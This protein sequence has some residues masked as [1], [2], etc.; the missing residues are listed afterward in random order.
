MFS[1]TR[2]DL[3]RELVEGQAP[4]SALLSPFRSPFLWL[5]YW[6]HWEMELSIPEV[7]VKLYY[8]RRN[9]LRGGR[10]KIFEIEVDP[11]DRL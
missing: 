6:L 11:R 7:R 2:N 5:P 10:R 1:W 3:S 8:G 9:F 4:D